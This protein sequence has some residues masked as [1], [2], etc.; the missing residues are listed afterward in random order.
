MVD[1]SF[2]DCFLS[3]GF[4]SLWQEMRQ[5]KINL[6]AGIPGDITARR[7]VWSMALAQVKMA[8]VINVSTKDGKLS[9]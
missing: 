7:P 9:P 3:S 6:W 1:G 8:T 2:R 5:G 4:D